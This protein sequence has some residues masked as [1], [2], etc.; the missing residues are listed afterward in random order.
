MTS[1]RYDDLLAVAAVAAEAAMFNYECSDSY[2]SDDKERADEIFAEAVGRVLAA[3]GVRVVDPHWNNREMLEAFDAE[4]SA[5]WWINIDLAQFRS[6]TRINMQTVFGL[7]RLDTATLTMEACGPPSLH[8]RIA[9][10]L[11]AERRPAAPP[12]GP[13]AN[14]K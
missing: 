10:M 6:E 3:H 13:T 7:R 5:Q 9:A 4:P 14:T 1:A 12:H 2:V 8:T 11:L